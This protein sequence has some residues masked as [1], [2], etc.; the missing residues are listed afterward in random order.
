LRSIGRTGK[1]QPRLEDGTPGCRPANRL[2]GLL[3]PELFAIGGPPDGITPSQSLPGFALLSFGK[4]GAHC[5]STIGARRPASSVT[6][7]GNKAVQ[8]AKFGRSAERAGSG[9][10]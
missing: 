8:L 1:G 3:V 6:R 10:G 9:L 4:E 2:P 7:H 5:A